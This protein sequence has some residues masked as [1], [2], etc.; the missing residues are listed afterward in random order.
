MP[1]HAVHSPGLPRG[2]RAAASPWSTSEAKRGLQGGGNTRLL[3]AKCPAVCYAK[4][5]PR[6]LGVF[7]TA[8]ATVSPEPSRPLGTHRATCRLSTRRQAHFIL[9]GVAQ[10]RSED[11]A[12][13]PRRGSVTASWGRCGTRRPGYSPSLTSYVLGPRTSKLPSVCLSVRPPSAHITC[14]GRC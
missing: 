2:W 1:A 9:L 11:K 13:P 5:G 14:P 4:Q 3:S 10:I 7:R 8:C 6:W 12:R